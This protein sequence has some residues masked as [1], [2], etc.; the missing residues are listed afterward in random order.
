MRGLNGCKGVWGLLTSG[1]AVIEPH[2]LVV[3]VLSF[4]IIQDSFPVHSSCCLISISIAVSSFTQSSGSDST[5]PSA[6][7]NDCDLVC[8]APPLGYFWSQACMELDK[9]VWQ[10]LCLPDSVLVDKCCNPWVSGSVDERDW[11]L[12]PP[13]ACLVPPKM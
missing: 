12:P 11:T 3:M 4:P 2:L 6:F 13:L 7:T 5:L 8:W 1:A 10:Q 9:R